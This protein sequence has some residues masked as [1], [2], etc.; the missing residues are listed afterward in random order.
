MW[1][2]WTPASVDHDDSIFVR[3]MTESFEVVTKVMQTIGSGLL[4]VKSSNHQW[5]RSRCAL[6]EIGVR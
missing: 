1:P 3:R 4:Y 2:A 5:F 6:G